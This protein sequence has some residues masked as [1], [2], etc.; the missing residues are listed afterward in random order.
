M[1][2][3]TSTQACRDSGDSSSC[4]AMVSSRCGVVPSCTN[5]NSC[6]QQPALRL[7][8]PACPRQL[9]PQLD[10][11]QESLSCSSRPNL[12]S[13]NLLLHSHY[14]VSSPHAHLPMDQK[15]AAPIRTLLGPG[16]PTN[17]QHSKNPLV[18]MYF[19]ALSVHP[20]DNTSSQ[21]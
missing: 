16:S 12:C 13:S 21:A 17:T 2:S 5:R 1:A 18:L 19:T 9:M 10:T 11:D 7:S 4:C 14:P 20:Q 6:G 15:C 8:S 3:L